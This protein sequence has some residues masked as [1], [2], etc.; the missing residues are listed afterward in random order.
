M[1]KLKSFLIPCNIYLYFIMKYMVLFAF[2]LSASLEVFPK[3][4]G[5]KTFLILFNSSDLQKINSSTEYIKLNFLEI[6]DAKSYSGNS[7]AAILVTVPNWD[8]DKCQMGEI[9]VQ[10][11]HT[12]WIPLKEIAFRIIDLNESKENYQ[13]LLTGKDGELLSK[14]KN[15]LVR[16]KL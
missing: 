8:M 14:S 3:E 4:N 12:T 6:F 2:L 9:L 5:E 7:D 11:N 13:A 1:G 16:L 15:Q 10:V